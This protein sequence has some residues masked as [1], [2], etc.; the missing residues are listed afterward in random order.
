MEFKRV[1]GSCRKFKMIVIGELQLSW[2]EFKRVEGSFFKSK[3]ELLERENLFKK[4]KKSVARYINA[5]YPN[6]HI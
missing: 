1:E 5:V 6:I 3:R 2:K 4:L